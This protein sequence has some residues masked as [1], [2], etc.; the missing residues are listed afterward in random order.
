MSNPKNSKGTIISPLHG[1]KTLNP[2]PEGR[3]K[4]PESRRNSTQSFEKRKKISPKHTLRKH[5]NLKASQRRLQRKPTKGT[6]LWHGKEL[7][8]FKKRK[9]KK[10]HKKHTSRTFKI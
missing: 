5:S 4:N 6:Y 7:K 3:E 2:K 9:G 1:S 10:N 8:C